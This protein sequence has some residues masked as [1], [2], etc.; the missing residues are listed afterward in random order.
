MASALA[1]IVGYP[2][3][4]RRLEFP[5]GAGATKHVRLSL[6][7]D[8]FLLDR[9]TRHDITRSKAQPSECHCFCLLGLALLE[10]GAA[11]EGILTNFGEEGWLMF[12]YFLRRRDTISFKVRDLLKLDD[13]QQVQM[14]ASLS[15][16]QRAEHKDRAGA[17][18]Q[19]SMGHPCAYPVQDAR[20]W[21]NTPPNSQPLAP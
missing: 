16:R 7:Q 17:Q 10:P 20:A 3:G 2:E 12:Q 18:T 19:Y 15:S 21:G 14:C 4:A 13:P 5:A 1:W 8:K 11:Y 6:P 9:C